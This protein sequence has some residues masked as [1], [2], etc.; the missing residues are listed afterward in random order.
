MSFV[1]YNIFGTSFQVT[2]RYVDLQP[3]GMGTRDMS[4]P[5]PPASANSEIQAHSAWFGQSSRLPAPVASANQTRSS[6]KDTITSS[7]VA[8]KKIVKPFSDVVLSKRTY[9]ELKLLKH[10]RHDN[11]STLAVESAD[12]SVG[13][14]LPWQRWLGPS[15]FWRH[16]TLLMRTFGFA[17]QARG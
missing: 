12:I 16:F 15:L 8:V 10:L 1:K 5:L 6:A 7:N 9:R 4:S 2:T 11:V 14:E 17:L 13:D 3:V